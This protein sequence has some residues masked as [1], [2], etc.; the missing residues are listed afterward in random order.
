MQDVP[1]GPVNLIPG[2]GKAR[3][4][5]GASFDGD[6]PMVLNLKG[7]LRNFLMSF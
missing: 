1:L 3:K 7:L 5:G 4:G 6:W 2:T